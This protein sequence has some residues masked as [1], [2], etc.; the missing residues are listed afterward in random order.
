MTIK[1]MKIRIGRDGQTRIS[2]EGGEGDNCLAFTRAVENAL[3]TVAERQLTADYHSVDTL[4]VETREQ[5]EER[6]L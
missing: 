4:A 3:G 5:L 1:K 6:G 2:V